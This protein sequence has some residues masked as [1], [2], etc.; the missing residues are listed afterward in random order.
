M[1][2]AVRPGNH[3]SMGEQYAEEFEPTSAD[4]I[5]RNDA[6]FREA[7]ER[8]AAAAAEYGVEG[9][10]P[11]ICECAEP[12]CRAIVRLTLDEYREVRRNPRHFMNAIG[13]HVAARG[14]AQVIA[15]SDSYVVVRKIGRAGDVAAELADREDRK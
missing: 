2:C 13:H 15:Q 1:F 9:R 6:M 10:V 14:W 8:I 7:N 3:G 12:M 4:R 11:F 5:A